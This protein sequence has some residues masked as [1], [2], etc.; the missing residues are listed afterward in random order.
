[1]KKLIQALRSISLKSIVGVFLAG[2]LLFIS[3]ACSSNP[4][5]ARLSGEGSINETKGYKNELYKPVQS[6]QKGGMYPYSDTDTPNRKAELK[7]KALVDNAKSNIS[8]VN[9]PQEFVENYKN[10]KPFPER[11]KDLSES[12]G[13]SASEVAD[14]WRGGTQ[15]GLRNLKNNAKQ[16]VDQAQDTAEDAGRAIERSL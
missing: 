8:K 11:V 4:P 7:G 6:E 12:I 3:T 15:R 2:S 10:G 1:M 9:N 14:D 16:G 13:D 5:T